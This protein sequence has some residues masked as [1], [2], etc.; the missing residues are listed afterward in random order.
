MNVHIIT[1]GDEIL[2]GQIVD[3]NSAWMGQQL[4]LIGA[5][6]REVRSVGDERSQILDA[7]SHTI[8]RADVVLIT[9]GLG[10]TKD[11][12]TKKVLA[13]FFD[14]GMVF[15][16]PT[17]DAI[18]AYFKKWNR[19]PTAAHREQC[20]MPAAAQLLV[21]KKGSAPGMWFEKDETIFVSMP[22][23]PYEMKYLME[24]EVLPRLHKLFPTT[25]IGHRTILTVGEGESRIAER[26]EPFL[27]RMPTHFKIAY[28]P[29]FGG[30]RLR[31]TAV[32]KN[33]A[34]LDRELDA[35]RDKLT[36]L[37]GRY[38]FGQEKDT[39]EAAVGRRLQS[40][41]KTLAIA[42]S[43]TGGNI[44][45]KITA[46]PGASAYFEGGIVAYANAVK[47]N[48]LGVPET[49]LQA[50]GAVSEATVKAMVSGTLQ[51][52]NSDIAVATSGVAGPGGGTPDK[53][54]GTIW[55]AV[56]DRYR[57]KTLRL[58][59]SHDRQQNIER[60]SI[61]AL[62]LIRLWEWSSDH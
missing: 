40:A 49:T 30:V 16:Q 61:V 8:G 11:D 28:L 7:L 53:P 39:L 32:G 22:G 31:L 35:Q 15:H 58:N 60:T 36:A 21:N 20:Y 17:Y 18:D 33:M 13:S 3:T 42:E 47:I 45:R 10:P 38:V 46:V 55:I 27:E 50:H 14:T 2:I 6:V 5:Q 34:V 29:N 4:N 54:V 62:N 25:A 43:C 23:V 44:A 56:G 51:L 12:I 1:I 52:F 9:G 24:Y 26:I 19:Q 37:L 41:G 57:T 48:T 59:L